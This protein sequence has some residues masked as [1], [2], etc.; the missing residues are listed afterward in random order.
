MATVERTQANIFLYKQQ[1]LDRLKLTLGY[2]FK[3]ERLLF[4]ALTHS[5]AAQ[6]AFRLHGVQVPNNERLEFLG[7]A[8]LGLVV[9]TELMAHAEYMVEGE[10][11]RFRAGV[12]QESVLAEV[13]AQLGLG[14][15]LALGKGEELSGGQ[16]K[17]SLLAD[18]FEAIIGAVYQDASYDQA[19]TVVKKV[20]AEKLQ[21]DVR[22]LLRKDFKSAL[23]EY[24]Q[25]KYLEMPVY[26]VI[27]QRGPAHNPEFEVV[28]QVRGEVLGT[29]TGSSKKRASQD[30]AARALGALME[31]MN[32]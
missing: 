27:T 31:S 3:D 21:G 9:A 5:S 28:V 26:H 18:A 4:E 1:E 25:S 20:M 29:G 12:V 14:S 23:Q 7:D 30:A 15:A 17:P 24:T 8:V 6:E 11:S 32:D 16:S 2:D 13:A 10:M 22:G 19:A